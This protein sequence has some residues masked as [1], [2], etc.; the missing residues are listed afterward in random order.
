MWSTWS[1]RDDTKGFK[2]VCP[3][4]WFPDLLVSTFHISFIKALLLVGFLPINYYLKQAEQMKEV[5][6]KHFII[7]WNH[8]HDTNHSQLIY[9]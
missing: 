1:E 5:W 9:I 2:G 8:K 3:K 7:S 4:G 6:A